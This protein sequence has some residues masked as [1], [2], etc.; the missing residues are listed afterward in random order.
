MKSI[1]ALSIL[2]LM[3]AILNSE[4]DEPEP[5]QTAFTDPWQEHLLFVVP[6]EEIN[7]GVE[8]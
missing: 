6:G 8:K 5:T 2:F 7:Q 1:L 3:F 4:P